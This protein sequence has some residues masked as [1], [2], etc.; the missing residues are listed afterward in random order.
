MAIAGEGEESA[1]EGQGESDGDLHTITINKDYAKRHAEQRHKEEMQRLQAKLGDEYA[2]ASALEASSVFWSGNDDGDDDDDDDDDEEEEEDEG[3]LDEQQAA[4]FAEA[5]YKIKDRDSS[6]LDPSTQLY[7]QQE[8]PPSDPPSRSHKSKYLK[9]VFAQ[10][11]IE[12]GPERL[13]DEDEQPSPSESAKQ[14]Q[15]HSEKQEDVRQEFLKAAESE[16][17]NAGELEPVRKDGPKRAEEEK[18]ATLPE[19]AKR[20]LER[21]F[22]DESQLSD[23]DRFLRDYLMNKRWVSN[24][25]EGDDDDDPTNGV[26]DESGPID[27]SGA[28]ASDARAA[29]EDA[30]QSLEDDEQDL[31]E[32]ER[33]ESAYNFR[34]EEPNSTE[35]VAPGRRITDTLRR[36]DTRR[37]RKRKEREER[38]Q[39]EKERLQEETNRLKRLKRQEIERKLEQVKHAAG[40]SNLPIN[41]NQLDADFDPDEHDRQMQQQFGD[42]FYESEEQ[43]PEELAKPDIDDNATQGKSLLEAPQAEDV[44]SLRKELGEEGKPATDVVEEDE[45]SDGEQDAQSKSEIVE[46]NQHN[47]LDAARSADVDQEACKAT[48]IEAKY[49]NELSKKREKEWKRELRN[50]L[51]EYDRMSTEDFVSGMPTRFKYREVKD[52]SFGLSTEEILALSDKEL[53]QV[54]SVKKL[55]PYREDEAVR[56]NREGLKKARNRAKEKLEE[57]KRGSNRDEEVREAAERV[58]SFAKPTKKG[59]KQADERADKV[60]KELEQAKQA[61]REKQFEGMSKA[62]KKNVKK[63]RNKRKRSRREDQE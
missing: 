51:R 55:A 26:A 14:L 18:A 4:E 56:V 40:T 21:Y 33:F 29:A 49:S 15:T 42:D 44:D 1:M 23:C 19:R 54:V 35:L 45:G 8:P 2:P 9:D 48:R 43:N 16:A 52:D 39:A 5:L 34:F 41:M 24:Y 13:V 17:E 37:K 12:L 20:G 31:E 27:S 22:G 59:L 7:S 53:N 38:K 10:Q 46:E 63:R 62:Q 6:V 36:E 47:K 50:K 60:R 57:L 28:A 30:P 58:Q 61:E 3:E 11:A 32:Q 25:T